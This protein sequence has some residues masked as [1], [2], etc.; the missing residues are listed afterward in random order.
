MTVAVALDETKF[1]ESK[2]PRDADGKFA[3]GAGGAKVS[4]TLTG[5]FTQAGFKKQKQPGPNGTAVYFHP[6]S[7]A[8][9]LVHPAPE[10]KKWSS[11]WSLSHPEQGEHEGEGSALAKLLQVAVAKG[12]AKKAAGTPA[13][14][15]LEQSPASVEAKVES[16]PEAKAYNDL[17]KWLKADK[18]YKFVESPDGTSAIW[19]TDQGAKV[20]LNWQTGEWL[21]VTP[22]HLTKEGKGFDKLEALFKGKVAPGV[23]NSGQTIQTSA[24]LASM[25]AAQKAAAIKAKQ[26]NEKYQKHQALYKKLKDQAPQPTA[27]QQGA[28]AK[29]SGSAYSSWNDKLRHNP[30]AAEADPDTKHLDE[31]LAG[32]TFEEEIVVRRGV[33]GEYA[34]I[35]KSIIFEGT[36]FI[37]RGYVST[38]AKADWTWSG[39]FV[40][41]ITCP[42]GSR[43][44]AIGKWSHYPSEMEVLLPRNSA[45][46]VTHYDPANNLV[47]VT[48]D[49]AHFTQAQQKEAA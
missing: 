3:S 40:F 39:G 34:K 45:F 44:A 4:S 32:A 18:G 25:T 14:T 7:G 48:L 21:A 9:V 5:I 43:G 37:D 6:G 41:E 29:Y 16:S 22:G 38:S 26:A 30:K 47:K 17:T 28:I 49:Q 42:K 13:G 24:E 35:L 19:A 15:S 23:Q 46:V 2:H 1:E 33:N 10:G 31:Y 27:P 11:K 36:K 20:K 12:A 8:K